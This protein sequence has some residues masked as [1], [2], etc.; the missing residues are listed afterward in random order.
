MVFGDF[1]AD[2]LDGLAILVLALRR[3]GLTVDPYVPSRLDEGHGLSIAAVDA[4]ERNGVTRH[5][6]RR[7]RIELRGRDLRRGRAWHRR[8]RHGP[9]SAARRPCRRPSRSSTRIAPTRAYPDVRLAGSGVA[10]KVAQLILADEPGGP[11][12]ALDLADLATIGTVAD[13]APIVGENRSIARL[14]L[15]QMRRAPAAR[16][17]RAP[18]ACP[19]R[20]RGHGP[21]HDRVC[22]GAAPERGR[23]GRGGAGGGPAPARGGSPWKPRRT[24]TRSRS[25]NKHPAR[26]HGHGRRGGTCPGRRGPGPTC[27]DRARSVAGRHRGPRRGAAGGGRLAAGDRRSRAR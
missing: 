24:P 2:G 26:P 14:G 13:V 11:A 23:A 25:A 22:A 5:R 6:H 17:R 21:R 3:Y 8:D 12:A 7:H 10:F 4:A 18:G 19:D 9:P 27:G 1:D 15:E 16:D 20:P